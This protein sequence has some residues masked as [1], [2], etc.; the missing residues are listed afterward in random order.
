MMQLAREWAPG[1]LRSPVSGR[2]LQARGPDVLASGDEAWPVI[3]GI[4]FLRANRVDMARAAVG[5]IE[6]G[7][8]V[9]ATALLLTDQDPYAPDPPPS[10]EECARLVQDAACSFRDAMHRLAFGRVADYFAHRWTDPTYLSGLA[11]LD[12]TWSHES[13][14]PLLEL[15]SGVGH[16]LRAASLA[17]VEADGTDLV[18]AK[19]WLARRFVCPQARLV[20]F[21]A[22]APWPLADGVYAGLFCH[23]A[24]YFLPDKPGIVAQMR[25]V[26]EAGGN[27][28]IGHAHNA[29]ADNHSAGDPL[30]VDAYA[31][32]FPGARLFD[33]RELTR[34]YAEARMPEASDA[35]SLASVPALSM[36]WR[37]GT[38]EE[39]GGRHGFG[40]QFEGARLRLNPLYRRQG[41]R[42]GIVWPSPRYEQEYAALATYPMEWAGPDE[43]EPDGTDLT[44]DLLRR[45]VYVDLP[46]RW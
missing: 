7:D 21:D 12:E 42:A 24:F 4:P 3:E 18:F 19:L 39:P 11:L 32:L 9:A 45:R 6:A 1:T 37:D 13:D 26:V 33:D 28:A 22:T 16:F 44:T 5:L 41:E 8:M 36:V 40:T 43:I 25:R 27:V 29:S 23:D 34:A 15:A 10:M 17:G 20:C 46:P 35:A 30:T 14:R 2:P 31:G 38:R